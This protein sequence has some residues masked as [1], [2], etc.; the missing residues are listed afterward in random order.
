MPV[1]SDQLGLCDGR[2]ASRPT[3]SSCWRVVVLV[4]CNV[5]GRAAAATTKDTEQVSLA[6]AVDRA[7]DRDGGYD[8]MDHRAGD[9]PPE[10]D[11]S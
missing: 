8:L 1:V 6:R 7:P 11:W 5:Q 4:D 3:R 10:I 9:E 2:T